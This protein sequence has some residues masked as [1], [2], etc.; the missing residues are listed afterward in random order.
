MK[1]QNSPCGWY[2][3]GDKRS[4]KTKGLA[5]PQVPLSQ[6]IAGAGFA[7]RPLAALGVEPRYGV[8]SLR[9][10]PLSQ[11]PIRHRY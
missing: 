9:S 5:L 4:Q 8:R 7:A 11:N 10:R 1:P 2:R 3:I 6:V